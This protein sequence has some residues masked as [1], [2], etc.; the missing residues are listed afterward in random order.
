MPE[1]AAAPILVCGA[2][3]SGVRLLAALLDG[4]AQL[5]SG[6]ELPFILT[7]AQQWRDIEAT[8]GRNHERHYGLA[9]AQVRAAFSSSILQLVSGRLTATGKSRFV[10]QSFGITLLLDTFAQLFPAAKFLLCV[11]DPRAAACSLLRCDWRDPRS[12]VRLPYTLDVRVAARFLSDFMH[13]ALPKMSE[14]MAAGRLLVVRYEALCTRPAEQLY[15]LGQFL[16][17]RAPP[18][19]VGQDSAAMVVASQNHE[20]PPLC[21]GALRTD[22][23]GAWH[24]LLAAPQLAAVDQLTAVLRQRFGYE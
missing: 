8:L 24:E 12:G 9:P 1:P 13:L 21:P 7:M 14:L 15:L 19:A 10:F 16:S 17:E 20:H 2:P 5:A 23:V 4:H 3:R 18:A 11:R 22:R 6:P